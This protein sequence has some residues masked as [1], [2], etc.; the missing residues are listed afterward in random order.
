M[1]KL[2]FL[3]AFAVVSICSVHSAWART[4][5]TMPEALTLESGQ[6]YCLYNVGSDRFADYVTNSSYV[7]AYA[8]YHPDILITGQGDGLYSLQ[9]TANN[10]YWYNN[11][12]DLYCGTTVGKFRI[13][14]TDGGYTIQPSSSETQYVG[15]TPGSDYVNCNSTSGNIVWQLYD[16]DGGEAIIRYRAKK[17][18][19]DALVSADDYSLSFATDEYEALYANDEAT[20]DELKAA[21]DAIN[22]GL[23][24][25]D[26]LTSGE[27]EF[28]VYTELTGNADWRYSGTT[29][30]GTYIGNGQ[31]GLKAVVDVDQ[32]ATVVYNYRVS[33]YVTSYYSF[34]VYLDGE[35][36]QNI[37][38]EEGR[39]KDQQ[40]FVELT[41]GKHTI[42]WV[43]TNSID[44]NELFYLKGVAVYKTPTITVNLTQAGSLGTEVLYNV[45]HIKDVRKLVVK[46]NMNADDW[47]RVNMMTSLF[48]LDLSQ[49]TI[50]SLPA[51]K[52][53]SFFHKLKLPAGL[54]TIEA[55]AL[56]GTNLEEVNFPATL[57]TI[58]EYALRD[59]RIKEAVLPEAVSSVGQY[60]FAENQ[61]LGKVVWPSGC[62]TIPKYCF[63][64]C[65]NIVDFELPEGITTI[66]DDAFYENWSCHYLIP[67]TVTSIGYM[68]FRHSGIQSAY[69]P[70]NCSVGG[71]AFQECGSLKYV[72]IGE[73]V[74]F[75][76]YSSNKFYTFLDCRALEEVVFPSTFYSIPYDGMLYGCTALK[77]VTFKSPTL[78]NGQYYN[79]FFS[80][81]GTDI[82]VYVPSY[83][84]NAYKLDS[85]WY[86]YNIMG[87]STA[88]VSWWAICNALT[89]YSQD[90]FE[91]VPDVEIWSNGSWAINGDAPQQIG[92]CL[93]V[94]WSQ[95]YNGKMGNFSK[96]I[97]TCDNVT[98]TQHYH[99]EYYAYN[100]TSGSNGRWHFICLPFDTRVDEIECSNGARFAVRYYDG[101]GRAANG[102]G[103]NWKDFAADAVIPAGTGFIIQCSK[104]CRIYFHSID[105]ETK[106]NVFSNRI[107]TKALEANDA[108]QTSNKGWNLVGNPWMCYYNIHKMNFTGPITTYDGYNRKYNA[109]SVID[110]DYAIEP[111]QAFFVQCPDEVSEISFP[112]DGRQ[113]TSVI[114]SQNGARAT[115]ASERKL[116]DVELS[117]GEQTD[118]ARFVLNPQASMD[119]ET[120]R[121]ASKFMEAGTAAPQIYTIEQGELLAINE[122]PMGNGTVQLG[123]TIGQSGTYTISAP[124]NQFRDIVLV[125]SETGTET[126]LNNE[127]SYT[128]TANA[129]I[130]DSRFMLRIGGMT[131]T[132][133]QS[134]STQQSASDNY[135]NLN[136]QRVSEPQKG[137]Y[138]VNGK[139]VIK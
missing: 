10:R 135:Y 67:S 119:Y 89:F 32:D 37:Q 26:M 46:G 116:I 42:E 34:S 136:G 115:Q 77:K 123:I 36:Y 56:N 91:G 43:A 41:A 122:R 73:G 9:F 62:T 108:E 20:N 23:K 66:G 139:K 29:Y 106:Q 86:N 85:Y 109:Y 58:G 107:F 129:G 88:D 126:A 8:D 99:H 98:V 68:A 71:T 48:D 54:T 76:T 79:T 92:N 21:A 74:S 137:L 131:I 102:T 96:V 52:P 118:K 40:Y 57:T 25:K 33:S 38:N 70:A 104:E 39:D 78:I 12:S 114:E 80:G 121:D 64:R 97:S 125:D 60:A 50:T 82:Q 65:Y 59:T 105:N 113:M 90:R 4:A 55:S 16:A 94:G 127:G 117:D 1:N 124:R 100:N 14:A 2:R 45:D 47:E 49:T 3:L 6:T 5:P 133:I 111:C 93:T 63:Y 51:V 7:Y 35:L 53:G 138:I 128:F 95:Q 130:D 103:G 87:F 112:V 19:Y 110:D 17:A 81:L 15:N 24:W 28:T 132:G 22:E 101:A 61:T 72:E 69:I 13:V 18:L 44:S 31:G 83:L 84:V 11:G 27:T 120:S 134:A 75:R 30:S